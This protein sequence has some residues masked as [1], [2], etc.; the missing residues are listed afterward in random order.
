MTAKEERC[1]RMCGQKIRHRT[2]RDAGE[3]AERLWQETGEWVR[4]YGPCPFCG[5]FHVGGSGRRHADVP[6]RWSAT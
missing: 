3:H 5:F 2:E 6:P 4:V 1:V